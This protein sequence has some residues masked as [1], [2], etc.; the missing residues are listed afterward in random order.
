MPHRRYIRQM[1]MSDVLDLSVSLMRERFA[2]LMGLW[3]YCNLPI[4]AAVTGGALAAAFAD[5]GGIMQGVFG[6]KTVSGLILGAIS[7]VAG[8]W[9]LW[10]FVKYT[11]AA[12]RMVADTVMDRKLTVRQTYQET[13]NRTVLHMILLT[14]L[15]IIVVGVMNILPVA[16]VALS[17]TTSLKIF[18]G[19]LLVGA[20]VF[21]LLLLLWLMMAIITLTLDGVTGPA[22]YIRSQKLLRGFY[23]RPVVVSLVILLISQI[24]QLVSY[25]LTVF[26]VG[27]A[28]DGAG[29][30]VVGLLAVLSAVIPYL[31]ITPVVSSIMMV[32]L[33]LIHYDMRVRKEGLD[34]HLAI[35]DAREEENR[36]LAV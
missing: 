28:G 3:A 20:V 16:A 13:P 22:A 27:I 1:T 11:P 5:D 17:E 7:V 32:S 23:W 6:V 29:P 34:L 30:V 26:I 9:G 10:R 36:T 18:S 24:V 15:M 4:A 19:F 31:T 21:T 8:M 25:S 14:L 2:A 33:V 35:R 12:V